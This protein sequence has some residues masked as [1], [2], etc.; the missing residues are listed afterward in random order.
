MSILN[1]VILDVAAGYQ[2]GEWSLPERQR[3]ITLGVYQIGELHARSWM[4]GATMS[5]GGGMPSVAAWIV[6]QRGVGIASTRA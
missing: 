5:S 3:P 4:V 6:V 1:P 2:L